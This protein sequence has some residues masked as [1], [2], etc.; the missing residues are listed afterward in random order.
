[1]TFKAVALG[2][3]V[4]ELAH[5]KQAAV[6]QL[7]PVANCEH[8]AAGFGPD[9][10]GAVGTPERLHEYL[11]RARGAFAS[12]NNQ[13]KFCLR[14]RVAHKQGP[15]MS[16]NCEATSGAVGKLSQ[17]G[18]DSKEAGS[19]ITHRFRIA[20]AVGSQVEN[21]TSGAF[22][23]LLQAQRKGSSDRSSKR[24]KLDDRQV[25]ALEAFTRPIAT[26]FSLSLQQK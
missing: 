1:M 5:V 26:T 9:D 11:C 10:G 6:R 15:E 14:E 23:F 21:Q 7:M 20:A 16:R 8:T 13:W 24:F 17:V 3:F 22:Q 18:A 25:S 2:R 4:V 19:D 12:Q